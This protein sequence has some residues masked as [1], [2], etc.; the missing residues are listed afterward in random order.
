MSS[1]PDASGDAPLPGRAV[2]ARRAEILTG[3]LARFTPGRLVDLATGTGWFARIAADIG[4][5]VTALD[6][7]RRDWPEHPGVTWLEQDVRDVDLAGYDLVLCLGIFYH[8]MLDDQLA[9]LA[10][11]AGTPLILDTHVSLASS[12]ERAGFTGRMYQEGGDMLSSWGNPESFWPDLPSLQ[13]MLAEHG[14]RT[15][16]P[17]EP[18]YHGDDRTFWVCLP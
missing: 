18:W 8:L 16:E 12:A 17:V 14:Y 10:K 7:R 4:W 2:D 11:C 1:L 15:I 13:R 9:L 6:A 5:Q 3:L